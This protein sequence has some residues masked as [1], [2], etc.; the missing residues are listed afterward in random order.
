MNIILKAKFGS[1]LY[2]T[3]T[4][5]S[6]MDIKG[7]FLPERRDVILQKVPKVISFDTSTSNVKN[8]ATD[9]DEEYYSLHYFLELA[10][11]GETV[12]MDLLHVRP[13]QN[14]VI[15]FGFYAYKNGRG[16]P[17]EHYIDI[18]DFMYQN[19]AKFYTKNMKSLL[20]YCRTQAAKYGLRSERLR[21]GIKVYEF[22][23]SL[24]EKDKT[25]EVKPVGEFFDSFPKGEH[26]RPIVIDSVDP[27]DD[28]RAIEVCSRKIMYNTKVYYVIGMVETFCSKYGARMRQA[29]NNSN[30]DW[31]AVSHSFRAGYEL[32]EIYETG[33]LIFPLKNAE[34]LREL[35]QGKYHYVNDGI[36]ERLEN[37]INNVE[38]LSEESNYP[39]KVDQKFWEDWLVSLY[40]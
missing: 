12:A 8:K 21:D 6:D 35:K 4:P 28:N 32:K 25:N 1:N 5:E 23:K 37:L 22:L 34:F 3:D 15:P 24:C 7:I 10:F 18:W 20:G 14:E 2:G 36:A 31:K 40:E 11:K 27:L 9:V 33:D 16:K 19:R 30:V 13:E 26:I 29:A 39:E 17:W 38:R